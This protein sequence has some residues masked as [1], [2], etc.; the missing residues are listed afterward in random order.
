M[1][2]AET[3]IAGALNKHYIGANHDTFVIHEQM[4][5]RIMKALADNKFEI[6]KSKGSLKLP[7]L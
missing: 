1:L 5:A 2:T 3:V 6:V 7:G 4:A